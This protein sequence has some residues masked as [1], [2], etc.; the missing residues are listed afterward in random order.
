MTKSEGGGGGWYCSDSKSFVVLP[1]NYYSNYVKA[2]CN[3]YHAYNY[4]NIE[5]G[6]GVCYVNRKSLVL[7]PLCV[8]GGGGG[9]GGGYSLDSSSIAD[10]VLC[11][12]VCVCTE[13]LAM[14]LVALLARARK[15]GT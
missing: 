7:L 12:C 5:G 6:K 4:E 10:S 8:W 1:Y 14:C 3:S 2:D 11:V 15:E 13:K 9:G